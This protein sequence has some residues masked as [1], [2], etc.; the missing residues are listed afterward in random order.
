[1]NTKDEIN[2]A[3]LIDHTLLK[4]DA[5]VNDIEKMCIEAKEYGF[6]AVCINPFFLRKA[7]EMIS[8]TGVRLVS[9]IGFPLGMTLRRVKLYEAKEAVSSGADELDIVMNIGAVKSGNWRS[10]RKEISDIIA[11]TPGVVHKIIIE[12]CYLTDEEKIKVSIAAMEEGAE[13]IKT[14]SGF[15]PGGAVVSDISLIRAATKEGIKIKAS[16]GIRNLKDV[17]NCAG[18]GAARIG[19]S[20]GVKIMKELQF[21]EKTQKNC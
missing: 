14:S 12:T 6:Y 7:G 9:V 4:P 15:G 17:L 18:A 1:M 5:S 10:L 21:L 11:A 13:F 2:V 16:G 19:T 20:S 8:G 3:Q